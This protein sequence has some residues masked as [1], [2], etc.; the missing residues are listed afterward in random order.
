MEEETRDLLNRLFAIATDILERTH[1][2]SA[3]GQST[4]IDA[5]TA[6]LYARQLIQAGRDIS[7]IAETVRLLVKAQGG[8][9][10]ERPPG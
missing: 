5:K 1:E 8:A 10:P 6:A 2:V 3:S 7:S 4:D 9:P